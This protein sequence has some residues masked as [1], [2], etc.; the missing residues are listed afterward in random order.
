MVPSGSSSELYFI[1]Y[2][3]GGH[4]T[5]PKSISLPEAE[6]EKVSLNNGHGYSRCDY[7]NMTENDQLVHVSSDGS[8]FA[9]ASS[10]LSLSQ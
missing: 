6:V 1:T 5:P 7:S 8:K 3:L 9:P 2:Q 10:R 4:T